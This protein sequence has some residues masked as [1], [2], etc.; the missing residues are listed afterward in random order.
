MHQSLSRT[1]NIQIGLAIL[2]VSVV[3][4]AIFMAFSV[5]FADNEFK[6]N[7]QLQTK[8]LA[9]AFTEQLWLFDLNSTEKLS[10][11][12][13]DAPDIKGLR[14][15]DHNKN[16]LIDKG[17]FQ[18]ESTI[19]IDEELR[20]GGRKL[21]GHLELSFINSSWEKHKKFI[22]LTGLSILIVTLITTLFAVTFLL[23]RH[24]V[25]PLTNLQ[26][27]MSK[28]A[29]GKFKHSNLIGQKT[30]IQ[31]IIDVFN[32]MA[33]SLAQREEEQ[34]KAEQ[35]LKKSQERYISLFNGSKDSIFTTTKAGDFVDINPAMLDL[36]GY[37]Q[38]EIHKINA[39]DVYEHQDDRPLFQEKIEATGFLDDCPVNLITKDRKVKNCLMSASLGQIN[40]ARF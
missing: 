36:L 24:L 21:V 38:E 4:S 19:L 23:E 35:E 40:L 33:S 26:K 37:T 15:L 6:K 32:K 14:L 7:I 28:L 22:L 9:D 16:V 10:D 30:E 5:H 2:F 18:D 13:L 12:A 31:N 8:H 29:D 20:Y 25:Q 39:K 1:L 17:S 34:H 11:L 27:D 3:I